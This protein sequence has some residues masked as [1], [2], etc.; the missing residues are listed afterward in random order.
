MLE[1]INMN[2]KNVNYVNYDEYLN[3]LTKSL[4]NFCSKCPLK[5]TMKVVKPLGLIYVCYDDEELEIKV[6]VNMNKK[7]VIGEIKKELEQDY[8]IIYKKTSKVPSADEV[9][10]LL[11]KG[12]SL[13]EALNT[14]QIVYEK[15]YRIERIHDRYNEIDCLDSNNE[16]Y[17]FKCKIPI[18][19]ILEDLKFNGKESDVLSNL[20]LLYKLG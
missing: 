11:D 2:A 12:I 4:S 18:M 5:P 8:P 10:K 9:Q 15:V 20:T 17:K 1:K 16:L 6:D 19:A 13:S 3:D 14:T 7:D